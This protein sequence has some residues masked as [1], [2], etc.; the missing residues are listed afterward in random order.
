M[1]L[2]F[3]YGTLQEP[4]VQRTIFGRL[5][6][7]ASDELLGAELTV[8]TD[9]IP[10]ANLTFNGRNDSRVNGTAFSISQSDLGTADRYEQAADYGRIEVTLVSGRRAWVYVADDSRSAR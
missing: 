2:V 6:R 4:N 1:P 5:L 7:G 8:A 9:R 3:A 10:H